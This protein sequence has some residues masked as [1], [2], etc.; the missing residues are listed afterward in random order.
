VQGGGERA[1]QAAAHRADAPAGVHAAHEWPPVGLLDDTALGVHGD[2][3]HAEGHAEQGDRGDQ[4]RE[5]GRQ[6]DQPRRDRG[7]RGRDPQHVSAV[8]TGDDPPQALHGD[9]R[10]KPPD[11]KHETDRA[12]GQIELG[13]QRGHPC[14]P[15]AAQQATQ[16]KGQERAHAGA[17]E[18]DTHS[19]V[20][21]ETGTGEVR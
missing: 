4:Q 3:H 20:R 1:Q 12:R 13:L 15:Y 11:Q 14:D 9:D 5:R 18:H 2:V 7:Q 10:R 21:R 17:G 8:G 16:G 19:F 6:A